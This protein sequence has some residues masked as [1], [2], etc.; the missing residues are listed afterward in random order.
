MLPAV[1]RP[2][3]H[4]RN[5]VNENVF[6]QTAQDA[7][8]QPEGPGDSVKNHPATVRVGRK[9]KRQSKVLP[10]VFAGRWRLHHSPAVV[11]GCSMDCRCT[12]SKV[13]MPV[14]LSK[15]GATRRRSHRHLPSTSREARGDCKL[16]EGPVDELD[17][18]LYQHRILDEIVNLSKGL[19]HE[20]VC[21]R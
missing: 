6:D 15:K 20:S 7:L 5:G 18:D 3:L 11:A 17:E 2:T 9:L 16:Q 4:F 13:T 8:V 1:P 10:C 19:V 14:V 21:S 12:G